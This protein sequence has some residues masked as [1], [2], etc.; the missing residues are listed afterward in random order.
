[1]VLAQPELM[2]RLASSHRFHPT[3]VLAQLGTITVRYF[4]LR[5]HPTMVLAQRTCSLPR[6]GTVHT[7]SI[8]LWFSLNSCQC[9]GQP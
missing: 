3:M 8:P 9:Q 4:F 1:M 6:T 7:V 2:V 5:F